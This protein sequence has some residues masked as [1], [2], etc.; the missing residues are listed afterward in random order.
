MPGMTGGRREREKGMDKR[1]GISNLMESR[2]SREQKPEE[3]ID[4]YVC[5]CMYVWMREIWASRGS[6]LVECFP[7]FQ[8][9]SP[10]FL[11][12]L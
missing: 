11:Y 7:S 12:A 9:V 3:K 6:Q 8:L 10:L 1:E 5:V 4:V 2:V